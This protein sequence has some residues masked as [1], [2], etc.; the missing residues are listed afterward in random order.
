MEQ[1]LAHSKYYINIY[2]V[3][4]GLGR[5]SLKV[6]TDAFSLLLQIWVLNL[7]FDYYSFYYMLLQVTSDI[8]SCEGLE[9]KRPGLYVQGHFYPFTLLSD[10]GSCPLRYATVLFASFFPSNF[11]Q[12]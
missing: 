3:H 9:T 5:L 11:F 12:H 7:P 6:L 8:C 1:L 10:L 4:Y 2:Y